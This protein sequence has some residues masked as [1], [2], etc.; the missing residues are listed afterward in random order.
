MNRS[1]SIYRSFRSRKQRIAK[2]ALSWD[3]LERRQ[4]LS[5]APAIPLATAASDAYIYGLAP[6]LE[7]YTERINTD[8]VRPNSTGQAPVNQFANQATFPNPSSTVIVR[9][10]ADTL[11]STAWLDLSKGPIVL[12]YPNTNGRYFLFQLLDAYTN[13]FAS[14]GART[15][16]T[17]AKSFLIAGPNW[18]GKVPDGLTLVKA[19]TNTV[20]IIGRTETLDTP[21]DIAAVN[22]L[23]AQYKLTPLAHWRAPNYKPP[24]GRV[25]PNIDT[26][27]TPTQQALALDGEQFFT[28]LAKLLRQNPPLKQDT[29]IVKELAELGIGP[30]DHFNWNRLSRAQKAA[31]TNAVAS[32][33]STGL[34]TRVAND[35]AHNVGVSQVSN[36]WTERLN[37]T[38]IGAYSTHYD[39]RAVIAIGG[40]GANLPQDAIYPS[41]SVDSNGVALNS[42]TDYLLHFD[43][44][45]LPPAGAFWSL[46]VYNQ[47]GYFV[48][49]PINR[50]STG[51]LHPELTYNADGSLDIYLQPNDPG[52]S[53]TSNWL[54]T[55]STPSPFNLTLRLY[56]PSAA[57]LNGTWTPLPVYST[58]QLALNNAATQA[59]EYGYPLV[60]QTLS[61]QIATDV[62][63][64]SGSQAP[65]NQLANLTLAPLSAGY[66][67]NAD[68]LYS[69]GWLDLSKEPI[70]LHV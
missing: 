55:P 62:P 30:A 59:Y 20:W 18:E 53:K 13:T 56:E 12:S 21:S 1:Q 48:S 54:P 2:P 50:Y 46:T 45:Q 7:Y 19:P 23:Q 4:L 69:F 27:D 70:V 22:A 28:L 67:P 60:L 38:E 29:T 17:A 10:N 36:G 66:G 5:A 15:D 25:D 57:A 24:E 47:N 43:K 16:G 65:V 42:G 11:Y 35:I 39:A 26:K 63:K 31:I 3:F 51:S 61:E 44:S 32:R 33:T 37:P 40:I 68:T 58:Q 9:P 14:L 52:G 41:T 34:P 8:V 49:N 6:V 64:V